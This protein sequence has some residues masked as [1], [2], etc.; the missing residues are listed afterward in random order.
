MIA[1]R[2]RRVP[3]SENRVTDIFHDRAVGVMNALRDGGLKITVHVPR[4]LIRVHAFGDRS[5]TG[6]V[7]EKNGQRFFFCAGAEQFFVARKFFHQLRRKVKGQ[8]L[9]VQFVLDVKPDG[10]ENNR[11]NQGREDLNQHDRPGEP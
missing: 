4:Q 3:E 6:N 10:V 11:G 5:E 2:V 7:A 1:L 8:R 9:L